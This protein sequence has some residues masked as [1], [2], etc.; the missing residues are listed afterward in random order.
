M[1]LD[2]AKKVL[3]DASKERSNNCYAEIQKILEKYNCVMDAAV[4]WKMGQSAQWVIQI[5]PN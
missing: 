5:I 4:T 1:E 2:E 3:E